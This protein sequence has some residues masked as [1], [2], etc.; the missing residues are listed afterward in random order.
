MTEAHHGMMPIFIC[1]LETAGEL[2]YPGAGIIHGRGSPLSTRS[3]RPRRALEN[4]WPHDPL[5]LC[6]YSELARPCRWLER[7][8]LTVLTCHRPNLQLEVFATA[9]SCLPQHALEISA[10]CIDEVSY[11]YSGWI[12]GW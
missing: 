8:L 12:G 3:W 4:H 5:W 1:G 6:L 7:F 2:R 10:S 9:L 11:S